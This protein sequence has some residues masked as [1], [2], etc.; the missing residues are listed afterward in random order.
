M[1]RRQIW[2]RIVAH[3]DRQLLLGIGL[4]LLTSLLVL[5]SAD[6]AS[7]SRPLSQ[8][9]N[10]VVALAVMWLVANL[11]LHYLMRTAV[12]IYVLG[13][14]LLVGIGQFWLQPL[15][16]ALKANGL[17]AGTPQEAAFARLHGI[18]AILYLFNSV[19]GLLLA[20]GFRF[21]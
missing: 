19:G 17:A 15:M 10:I 13:M 5:Y 16:V 9:R 14:V 20:A 12:P 4:L 8:M 11:P 6:N 3:I 1:T 2:L 7:W 18:A 21:R